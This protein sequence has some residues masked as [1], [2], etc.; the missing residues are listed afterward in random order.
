MTDILGK[1]IRIEIAIEKPAPN[2]SD[3]QII[4]V[5]GY[6]IA[7]SEESG[8]EPVFKF[9]IISDQKK[10]QVETQSQPKVQWI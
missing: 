4:D 8:E 9:W 6:C 7:I 1:K 5:S 10:P 2:Q 3:I